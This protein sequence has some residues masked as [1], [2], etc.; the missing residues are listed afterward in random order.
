MKDFWL[1]QIFVGFLGSFWMGFLAG[2]WLDIAEFSAKIVSIS[3][4]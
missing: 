2:F 4:K 1:C 3:T